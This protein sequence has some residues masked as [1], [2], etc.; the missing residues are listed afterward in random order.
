[1]KRL[2]ALLVLVAG[3]GVG[4]WTF[5][6]L[7]AD[8]P[9]PPAEPPSRPQVK[10]WDGTAERAYNVQFVHEGRSLLLRSAHFAGLDR[11]TA[12]LKIVLFSGQTRSG[13]APAYLRPRLFRMSSLAGGSWTPTLRISPSGGNVRAELSY[14]G[15]PTKKLAAGALEIA[16]PFAEG[17]HMLALVPPRPPAGHTYA[18]K[19]PVKTKKSKAKPTPAKGKAK[20]RTQASAREP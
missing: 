12:T 3:A 8:E 13:K 18:E 9:P 6:S 2:L 16:L 1:M 14:K 5:L 10:P 20:P 4:A 15:V 11:P 17:P 7:P 19:P